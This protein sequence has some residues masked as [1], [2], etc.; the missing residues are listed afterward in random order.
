MTFR[1]TIPAA[2]ALAMAATFSSC[3]DDKYDLSD[4]DTTVLVKVNDLT[5]PIKLDAIELKSILEEGDEIKIIDGQYAITEDGDFESAEIS[6]GAVTVG[7]Q[8]FNPSVISVPF[9]PAALAAAPEA[10]EF[11]FGL[12]PQ[13]F[14]FTANDIPAEITDV[15]ALGGNL[16]FI[17]RFDM[18]GLSA[19]ANRVE[20][21]DL[22]IQ[23]P[24]GLQMADDVDGAYDPAT[25]IIILPTQT[26][27]GESLTLTLKATKIDLETMGAEFDYATHSLEVS[28]DYCVKS[29]SLVIS[30][31]DMIPGA[32][33]TN[34]TMTIHYDIPAFP[35]TT[36]S[37]R[38]KYDITGV[39][40]SDVD[41]SDLPDVL[42]QDGTDISIVN[43]CI[44]ISLVNPLGRYGLSAQTGMTITSWHGNVSTPYSINDPGYFTIVPGGDSGKSSYCL[45]PA[46]P[47]QKL[48]GYESAIHVPFSDLSKVLSGQGLPSRLG[49]S[50]DDPNVNDQPVVD[51][52]LGTDIGAVTGTYSFFAPIAL[53]SGSKIVYSD[54]ADG[55]GSEDLDHIT[56]TDLH[57]RASIACDI[58]LALDAKAYPIDKDGNDIDGVVIEGAQLHAGSE[59]Q[60]VDIHISGEI[61]GGL[62]GIRYEVIAT[63][64]DQETTLSPTMTIK[65]TNLRP[66]VSGY[67]EKEL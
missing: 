58:P 66:T 63:A 49:I 11:K 60:T 5:V 50:L 3:V 61:R 41:L 38:V 14:K 20:L 40:I 57:V 17:F 24:K 42:T 53:C 44:Y 16:E 30:K 7:S 21:R 45:S 28:G 51:L 31:A 27:V 12:D 15:T 54:V 9:V 10:G 59:P 56:I 65:V 36:F 22:T 6:I 13:E 37:G 35:V 26:V 48:E 34:L 29:A 33:P 8:A 25:G 23:L 62:D 32:A 47:A 4:I 39:N 18:S 52:P 64:G 67:Y 55:W 43:P 2:L 46:D 1:H 19:I